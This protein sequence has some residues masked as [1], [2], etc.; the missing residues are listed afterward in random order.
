MKIERWA[1]QGLRR[2]AEP[3]GRLGFASRH[4]AGPP[5]R[6]YVFKIVDEQGN[7]REVV[8]P[9]GRFTRWW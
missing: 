2:L 3:L 9:R 6:P 5:E 8:A 1:E 7:E 4:V